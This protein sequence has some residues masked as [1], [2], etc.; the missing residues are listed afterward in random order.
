MENIDVCFISEAF[1]GISVYTDYL[2]KALEKKFSITPVGVWLSSSSKEIVPKIEKTISFQEFISEIPNVDHLKDKLINLIKNIPSQ[3]IH[4]QYEKSFFPSDEL[5]LEFLINIHKSTTKK[6]IVTFHSIYIDPFFIQMFRKWAEFIDTIVV[7][8]ENAKH[9][10]ISQGLDPEKII[11]IPH[12]TPSQNIVQKKNRFFK[13]N[14]FKILM[15]GILKKTKG[16]DK[17]LRSL[18]SDKTL[19]IIVSGWFRDLNESEFIQE[20]YSI[21]DKSSATLSIIPQYLKHEELI[22][23]ITEADCVVLPYEQDYFSSSGIL[24][25]VA[26]LHKPMFV[27]TSPKFNELV[28]IAPFCKVEDS[29]Y[30]TQIQELQYMQNKEK[31]TKKIIT[32]AESTSWDVIAKK[33]YE[34][35]HSM[36]ST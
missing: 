18:I 26:G 35:Y 19:E 5:F 22:D 8:Q 23:L 10:L 1:G 17:A 20:L 16:F 25:L 3:L 7:H 2:M 27:S 28:K 14:L 33:T 15:V 36:V 12:G 6:I 24:H 31:I 4:I 34:L 32:F 29:N 9:F 13:T 30:L 21:Q 11:T